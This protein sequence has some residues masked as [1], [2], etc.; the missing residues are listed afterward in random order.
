[1]WAEHQGGTGLLAP[2]L[3]SA[4]RWCGLCKCRCVAWRRWCTAKTQTFGPHT[5]R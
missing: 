5:A 4:S 2:G 3:M 1:M